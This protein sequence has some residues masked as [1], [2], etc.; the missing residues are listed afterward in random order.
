MADHCKVK[1]CRF[2]TTHVTRGHRCGRCGAFGHGQ[3]ECRD[4][5]ARSQLFMETI[6]DRMPIHLWCSIGSCPC[7][8]THSSESHYCTTCQS[9]GVCNCNPRRILCP[10][11][12]TNSTYGREIFT[13]NECIICCEVKPMVLFETCKHAIICKA[14][15]DQ[16][17]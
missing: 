15:A 11:C 8:S 16:I 6:M 1:G 9:R 12:R 4:S 13:Q 10:T 17:Q 7:P 14:C 3:L 5:D 2:S